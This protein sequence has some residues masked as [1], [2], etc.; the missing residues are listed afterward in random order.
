[1][2]A[3]AVPA[4]VGAVIIDEDAAAA[5]E[6]LSALSWP[7][8]DMDLNDF[9]DIKNFILSAAEVLSTVKALL[10]VKALSGIEK[11]ERGRGRSVGARGRVS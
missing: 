6:P 7:F 8:L 1:M 4:P 2:G 3:R 9:F 5:S 10:L 11:V